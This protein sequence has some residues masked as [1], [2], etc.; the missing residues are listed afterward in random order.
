MGLFLVQPDLLYQQK[1]VFSDAQIS[2]NP[3]RNVKKNLHEIFAV[4]PKCSDETKLK[5]CRSYHSPKISQIIQ[6]VL[7]SQGCMNIYT[8]Y[9]Y[10]L[11]D[12]VSILVTIKNTY[13]L[14]KV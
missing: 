11:V 14:K 3:Q 6:S 2:K 10:F 5:L 8:Y 1:I 12:T 4:D 9:N 13:L 7:I